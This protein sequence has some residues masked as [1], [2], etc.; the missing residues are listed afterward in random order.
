MVKLLYAFSVVCCAL[1]VEADVSVVGAATLTTQAVNQ[2]DLVL[3]DYAGESDSSS[4]RVKAADAHQKPEARQSG[5]RDETTERMA[6]PEEFDPRKSPSYML[7][8]RLVDL[9]KSATSAIHSADPLQPL[10]TSTK[11]HVGMTAAALTVVR[12]LGPEAEVLAS[13]VEEMLRVE[14][15]LPPRSSAPQNTGERAELVPWNS[16]HATF[17]DRMASFAATA[18]GKKARAEAETPFADGRTQLV[19]AASQGDVEWVRSV[20]ATGAD[21]N[22]RVQTVVGGAELAGQTALHAAALGGHDVVADILL[23]NGAKV[24]AVAHG[25]GRTTPAKIAASKGFSRTLAVILAY[26]ADPTFNGG[27]GDYKTPIHMAAMEG[28]NTCLQLLLAALNQTASH[29]QYNDDWRWDQSGTTPLMLAVMFGHRKTVSMLLSNDKTI[30]STDHVNIEKPRTGETALMIGC[31]H[32]PGHNHIFHELVAHGATVDLY[33]ADGKNTLMYCAENIGTAKGSSFDGGEIWRLLE[34]KCN[35]Q[36]DMSE[37][38]QKRMRKWKAQGVKLK[39]RVPRKF[40]KCKP[41]SLDKS[42]PHWLF[43]L[44]RL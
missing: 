41:K 2:L 17:P 33:D 23:S 31:K 14:E 39:F 20:L 7:V 26:G 35:E 8:Q 30:S 34:G 44:P 16:R 32:F 5:T 36:P 15:G 12:M 43:S 6:P 18:T 9:Q 19:T 3:D 29:P 10:L 21:V 27:G 37:L 11:A 4:A 28:H 13:R 40:T 22:Q 25:S 1:N 42:G 38:N 24:N